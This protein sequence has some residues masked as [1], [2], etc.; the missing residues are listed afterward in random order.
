M[1][2]DK[3]KHHTPQSRKTLLQLLMNHITRSLSKRGKVRIVEGVNFGESLSLTGKQ[4][5]VIVQYILSGYPLQL[6]PSTKK[7][8]N[9]AAALQ[10]IR[11]WMWIKELALC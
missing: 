9:N 7:Q 2:P 4:M 6:Q 3:K 10:R 5:Y 8:L 11:N 1:T